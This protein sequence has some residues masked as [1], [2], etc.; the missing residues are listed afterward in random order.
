MPGA[1]ARNDILIKANALCTA[2]KQAIVAYGG[3]TTGGANTCAEVRRFKILT[4][5]PSPSMLQGS[6]CRRALDTSIWQ[7]S[8]P[9]TFALTGYRLR[10]PASQPQIFNPRFSKLVRWREL[11]LF[12]TSG[13]RASRIAYVLLIFPSIKLQHIL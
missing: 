6:G 12:G 10:D 13:G 11:T 7:P 4:Y 1:V 8:E 3:T 9:E 5:H 2:Q